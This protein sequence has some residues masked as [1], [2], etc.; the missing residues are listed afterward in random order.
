MFR[1]S[2]WRAARKSSESLSRDRNPMG[3]GKWEKLADRETNEA[4][5]LLCVSEENREKLYYSWRHVSQIGRPICMRSNH[6][7]F[8]RSVG[9]ARLHLSLLVHRYISGRCMHRTHMLSCD[10]LTDWMTGCEPDWRNQFIYLLFL[11][12][13][14]TRARTRCI[15]CRASPS[16]F[17]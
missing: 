7:T 12:F 9:R 13:D 11:S 14:H 2:R 4:K 6:R 10:W 15:A 5:I 8:G 3:G 17:A 16:T 1:R